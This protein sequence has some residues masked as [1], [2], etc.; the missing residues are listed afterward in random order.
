MAVWLL[1]L[2][3]QQRRSHLQGGS[4]INTGPSALCPLGE[5][6]CPIATGAVICIGQHIASIHD[7]LSPAFFE[8]SLPYIQV[9][10]EP[11]TMKTAVDRF[12]VTHE[13]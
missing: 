8:T 4:R 13:I 3:F 6:R 12:P 7:F 1:A 5:Q 10:C 11:Q 9:P 2:P